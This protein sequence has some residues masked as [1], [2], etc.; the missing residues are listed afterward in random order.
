MLDVNWFL[1]GIFLAFFAGIL[2]G[3]SGFGF[4]MTLALGLL[5][6]LPPLQVIIIV[7]TLDF[8]GALGL[9]RR[10]WRH[11]DKEVLKRL[12]PMMVITS[13]LGVLFMG[14]IPPQ[15][16]KIIVAVLCFFGAI[17]SL[18]PNRISR[19]TRRKDLT[20]A[21]PAGAASGL[22]MTV[23][24]AGGPPMMLYLMNTTLSTQ[25]ARATANI[26][27]LVASATALL[28]YAISG[29]LTITLLSSSLILLPSA[30]LGASL[31]QYFF[32]RFDPVSY[33]MIVSPL[34]I[35][36]ALSVLVTELGQYIH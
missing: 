11:V 2:R 16:A 3:Y 4:A 21:L 20:L 27:F 8:L 33:R 34:L 17:L 36:M 32:N 25:T 5:W 31:G 19:L 29:H 6:F 12:T 35:L 9:I 14:M 28:G 30:L 18:I 22:A 15:T 1:P 13:C 23:A 7:L 10:A 26:F 24:S